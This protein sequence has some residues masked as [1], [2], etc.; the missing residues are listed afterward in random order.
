MN[1]LLAM[2]INRQKADYAAELQRVGSD[3]PE[4]VEQLH[5]KLMELEMQRRRYQSEA[6]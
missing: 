4:R 1:R 2:Q 6:L 3:D 5:R